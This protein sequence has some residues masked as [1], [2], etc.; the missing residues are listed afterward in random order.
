MTS[1]KL[2]KQLATLAQI[3]NL[4]ENAMDLLATFQGHDIRIHRQFYRLPDNALQVAKVSK[5]MHAIN[6]GTIANHK[7]CDFD[8]ITINEN[9]MYDKTLEVAVP[10]YYNFWGCIMI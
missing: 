1:T 9:G 4:K 10:L 5:H 3:L 7:G 2:R 8:D 6:N